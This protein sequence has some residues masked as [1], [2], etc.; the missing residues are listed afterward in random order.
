MSDQETAAQRRARIGEAYAPGV[1]G[2]SSG[3]TVPATN[4]LP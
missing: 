4:T 2:I 1:T 3:R